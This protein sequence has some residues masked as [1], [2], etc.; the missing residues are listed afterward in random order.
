MTS[1][2]NCR[3]SLGKL[4]KFLAHVTPAL[5]NVVCSLVCSWPNNT[6]T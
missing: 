4:R 5:G 2:H 3:N 1:T 6:F